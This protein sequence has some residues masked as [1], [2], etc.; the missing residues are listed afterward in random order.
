MKEIWKDIKNYENKYKVSNYGKIKNSK[1]NKILKPSLNTYG[2]PI[3]TLCKDGTT[4]TKTIHR[5]VAES[6]I[7]NSNNLPQVN[8]IDGNKQNNFI[9]NLEWVT[10][11]QNIIHSYK[12]G[13]RNYPIGNK[14]NR[15]GKLGRKH[16]K[17]KA[18][19]QYDKNLNIIAK[20]G[21]E[22]EAERITGIRQ[23]S[24]GCCCRNTQKTA[25]GYIWKFERS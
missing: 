7:D 9:T 8:H 25:G 23:S 4:S 6:F 22:R 12:K 1:T 14:N 15:Y 16:N 21:S 11:S 13:L 19:I 17:S 5:L 20:Y 3:V 10:I 2:Y 24:I 18:V